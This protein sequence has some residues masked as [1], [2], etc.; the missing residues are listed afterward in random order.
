[1]SAELAPPRSR[2]VLLVLAALWNLLLPRM[3]FSHAPPSWYVQVGVAAAIFFSLWAVREF[4]FRSRFAIRDGRFTFSAGP[5]GLRARVEV[6]LSEIARFQVQSPAPNHP[7][8]LQLVLRDGSVRTLNAQVDSFIL[9]LNAG[10]R[11]P[12]AGVAKIEDYSA[13]ATWLT[14]ALD[15]AMHDGGAYRLAPGNVATPAAAET[16]DEAEEAVV[17]QENARQRK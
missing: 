10:K 3:P 12:I 15:K 2:V 1:M 17:V 8:T 9:W 5:I 14:D 13:L 7:S 4:L 11:T 6:P 16:V